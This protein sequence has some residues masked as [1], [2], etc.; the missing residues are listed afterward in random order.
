VKFLAV[1][2]GY[3]T[4]DVLTVKMTVVETELAAIKKE[5]AAA[6]KTA[7]SASNKADEMKKFY[8]LLLKRVVKLE[9]K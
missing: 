8:D 5:A 3:E 4:L 2:T 7:H 1:N 9:S 6:T